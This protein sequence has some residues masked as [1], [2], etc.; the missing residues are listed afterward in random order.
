MRLYISV[1]MEGIAGI[2]S[3]S[4]LSRGKSDY[5]QARKLM[6]LEVKAAVEAAKA[7]GVEYIVVNDAHANM[8]NL[9]VNELPD[10]VEIVY[11]SPKPISMVSLIDKGFDA[12][13]F[14]GYHSRKGVA[15]SIWDH[16]MSGVL[17]QRVIVN[18]EEVSEFWLN[19][20][21]AGY[22]KVPVALVTGD[23]KLVAHA[24]S[25]I[26][27][28]EVVITKKS[29]SRSAAL[30][31]HPLVIANT[32]KEA[33]RKALEKV[34]RKEIKPFAPKGPFD[35]SI[36]FTDSLIVDFIEA[37]PG[38]ERIDGLTIRYTSDNIV[39]AY[40]LLELMLIVGA[41]VRRFYS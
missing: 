29:L 41:G 4:Q 40:N 9:L 10:Y 2:V 38:I 5:N 11:G 39:N 28:I 12:A 35:I 27:N 23:D 14:L 7:Y 33:V 22:Y 25:L 16:T 34:E 31:K 8:T 32:I 37:I 17:I 24:K 3:S 19:S 30:I 13:F 21:V 36:E 15:H 6:T 20:A 1:D 18:G 26:P